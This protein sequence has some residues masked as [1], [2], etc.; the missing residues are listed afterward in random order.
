MNL[1]EAQKE[2]VRAWISQGLKLSE[3]QNKLASEFGIRMTYM[4]TRF[5]MDDL[6]LQHYFPESTRDKWWQAAFTVEGKF[7]ASELVDAL[8]KA[9]ADPN[10]KNPEGESALMAVAR[11]GKVDAAKRLLEAGA[12]INAKES[13]GGQTA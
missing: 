10:T 7:K 4:E 3:I 9:G 8:L 2:K 11:T 13:V 5:L 1:D 6:K 12:D